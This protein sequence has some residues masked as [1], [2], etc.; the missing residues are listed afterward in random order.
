MAQPPR[1]FFIQ[2]YQKSKKSIQKMKATE[3]LGGIHGD[4]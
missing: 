4:M 1:F 2:V 3:I